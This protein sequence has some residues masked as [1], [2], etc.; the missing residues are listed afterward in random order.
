MHLDEIGFGC[1]KSELEDY[2]TTAIYVNGIN[3]KEVIEE[4]EREQV[5]KRGLRIRNGCYEGVSFF[6]AFHH[7]NHFLG[8]T[9]NDYVYPDQQYTLYDYKYSGIPGDHS[10]TCKISVG[11]KEVTWHDFKNVSRIIPFE[12]DYE[13]LT[14][15]FCKDQYCNAIDL[16][17]NNPEESIFT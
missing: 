15:R 2:M 4:I 9:L 6:I 13:G 8:K 3:L 7:Q 1:L 17:R 16:A 10:L 5:A 11:S 14:F 12:L